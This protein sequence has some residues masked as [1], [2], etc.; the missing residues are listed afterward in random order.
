MEAV[1]S[2]LYFSQTGPTITSL[3]HFLCVASC[4]TRPGA[5]QPSHELMLRF[6]AYFKQA[7]E[8]PCKGPRPSFWEVVK[9]VKYDAWAKLGNMPAEE[10]MK[11]YVDEL[12]Q[13]VET[14]SYTDNV[15]KFMGSLDSV[16]EAIPA[17]DLELLLGPTLER[18]RSMPGSPLSN[19]PL[20]SRETSPTRTGK[21]APISSSLGSSPA[22]SESASPD[23]HPCSSDEG[24]DD[25]D[26]DVFIDTVEINEYISEKHIAPSSARNYSQMNGLHHKMNGD[27]LHN[28]PDSDMH[29]RSRPRDRGSPSARRKNPSQAHDSHDISEQMRDVVLHLQKDL[30]RITARVRSLEVASLSR[31]PASLEAHQSFFDPLIESCASCEDIRRHAEALSRSRVSRQ[32]KWWPFR[33]LSPRAV[34]FITA[35]PILVHFFM[36]WLQRRRAA[37]NIKR[38]L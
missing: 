31:V 28:G 15:A 1:L 27:V 38:P 23:T 11:N 34:F 36:L 16:Y 21:S 5:F 13:I 2:L 32:P 4:V 14:M 8:G 22:S 12:R 6:Y 18:M 9:K 26:E 20:G 7:S 24:D 30:D 29:D 25:E 3:S 10:A 33:D 35:W 19:S 37:L 17:S